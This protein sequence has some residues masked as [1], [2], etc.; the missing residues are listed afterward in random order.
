MIKSGGSEAEEI[1][2]AVVAA[3][4]DSDDVVVNAGGGWKDGGA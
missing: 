1:D 2:V 3:V 4:V